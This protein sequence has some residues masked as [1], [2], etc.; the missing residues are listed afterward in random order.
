[1]ANQAT[2]EAGLVFNV[3]SVKKDLKLFYETNFENPNAS[4]DDKNEDSKNK[5]LVVPQFT[6]GQ[7]AM[8]AYIQKLYS[9]LLQECLKTVQKD[10]SGVRKVSLEDLQKAVLLHRGFEQYY[11]PYLKHFDSSNIYDHGCPVVL[12]EMDTV[13]DSV[14]KDLAFTNGAQNLMYYLLT[15]AFNDVAYTCHNMINYAGN[16]TFTPRCVFFAVK[17]KFH[18]SIAN[19]LCA[20]IATAIKSAGY[21]LDRHKESEQGEET[22]DI[23]DTADQNADGDNTAE[24]TKETK[25]VKK[26]KKDAKTDGKPEIK[27]DQKKPKDTKPVETKPVE[28][29]NNNKKAQ[30]ID[31]DGDDATADASGDTADANSD[32]DAVVETKETKA[33]KQQPKK[34]QPKKDP[35]KNNGKP[36]KK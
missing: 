31:V 28:K 20:A 35:P 27:V 4:D 23:A 25:D 8:T 5:V 10:I 26:P 34:D 19:D 22:A 6:G 3:E 36:A 9:L 11:L 33:P 29:K 17:S 14:S 24:D 18:E 30:I 1:M 12:A 13:K 16:R 21:R 15:K 2:K 7:Q 32:A